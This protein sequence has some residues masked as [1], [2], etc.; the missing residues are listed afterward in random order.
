MDNPAGNSNPFFHLT[1]VR[2]NN[3]LL[4]FVCTSETHKVVLLLQA[5]ADVNALCRSVDSTALMY[6]ASNG[7]VDTV[8]LL[9]K[10][11][12]QLDRI[13]VWGHT[14]LSNAV[15]YHHLEVAHLLFS[16][17]S[18]QQLTLEIANRPEIETDL[19]H[20]KN[21]VINHRFS[22]Y[23]KLSSLFLDKNIKNPFAFLTTKVKERILFSYLRAEN[24]GGWKDRQAALDS[25]AIMNAM[26]EKEPL[27]FSLP[28]PIKSKESRQEDLS[29]EINM[30]KCKISPEK[31]R[32]PKLKKYCTL[33]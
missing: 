15:R 18:L 12:A 19:N 22:V 10:A 11:G 1:Q 32:R 29:H 23:K 24:K 4:N 28:A 27:L 31:E 17:M 20:Y 21:N 14:A 25:M 30:N 8:D 33:F 9:I 6:A 2:K 5:G 7:R 16:A 13:N 26:N 3:D